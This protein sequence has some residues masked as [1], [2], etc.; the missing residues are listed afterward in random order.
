MVLTRIRLEQFTAFECLDFEP[1][2]GVNV[3]IG[4]NSTGKTHLMKV[5]YAACAITKE[6]GV[7]F[8]EKLVRV[9]LPSQRKIGRLTRRVRGVRRA[10]VEVRRGGK[11][12]VIGFAGN[13]SKPRTAEVHGEREWVR[14]PIAATYIPV[15]EMLANAPGFRSL[16]REREIH[17]DEIYSD[18][19]DRA[20]L[21]VLRGPRDEK[22]RHAL[23][24]IRK[25]FEIEQ[26]EKSESELKI[27][28]R[29]EEFFLKSRNGSIEFTLLAE[30][31]RKIGLLW[32][33]IENGTLLPDQGTVL[34]W[35][36][37][38]A[39]LNPTLIGPVVELLLHLARCGVQ[40]FVAT[41]DYVVLK[42]LDLRATK[43]H[44]VLYHAL[45]RDDVG[46][47]VK[48]RS[49]RDVRSIEPNVI[50]ETFSHLYEREMDRIFQSPPE[51]HPIPADR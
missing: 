10:R 1:S 4:A 41:H 32:L 24:Q 40:I 28:L 9:F 35:D 47:G 42:E 6:D 14:Q 17:F 8:G 30:G 49:T 48:I 29:G 50:R 51:T 7:G 37:P 13:Q 34:F 36:E 18:L 12:L 22:R 15:K 5:A 39:N 38:E 2:P 43:E 27:E 21:P 20:Y 3:F 33:L 23:A 19:L 11:R 25:I 46:K 26:K 45:Y 44:D 16:Y 31:L